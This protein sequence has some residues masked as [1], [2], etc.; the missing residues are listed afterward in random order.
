VV[1]GLITLGGYPGITAHENRH[2]ILG[3]TCRLEK[4]INA[5]AAIVHDLQHEIEDLN[6]DMLQQRF[7]IDYL[8]ACQAV[9][10]QKF[11]QVVGKGD[12]HIPGLGK[13]KEVLFIPEIPYN[14]L[15][16]IKL[17][18]G[19]KIE[20]L[21]K[22]GTVQLTND[23][24]EVENVIVTSGLPY[25]IP[26]INTTAQVITNFSNDGVKNGEKEGERMIMPTVTQVMGK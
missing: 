18:K 12:V 4:S 3:L 16:T 14:V 5:T 15:A 2:S 20:V 6:Q 9:A 11:M 21:F 1:T 26:T 19:T 7:A 17:S 8:L 25:F 13:I 23:G 24:K 22:D 10:N